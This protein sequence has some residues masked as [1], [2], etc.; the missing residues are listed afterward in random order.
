MRPR[1][2]LY[3]GLLRR[4]FGTVQV[5]T[6]SHVQVYSVFQIGPGSLYRTVV[7]EPEKDTVSCR[8]NTSQRLVLGGHLEVGDSGRGLEEVAEGIGEAVEVTTGEEQGEVVAAEVDGGEVEASAIERQ[9]VR[10]EVAEEGEAEEIGEVALTEV[11]KSEGFQD[12]CKALRG[13]LEM[14][15]YPYSSPWKKGEGEFPQLEAEVLGD[16]EDG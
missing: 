16:D 14:D 15:K 2:P 11:S 1:S 10:A 6:L 3:A 5:V 13:S 7:V 12:L 8:E 4:L 9:G